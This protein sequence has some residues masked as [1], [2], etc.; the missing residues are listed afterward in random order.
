MPDHPPAFSDNAHAL[1]VG[2]VL[3]QLKSNAEEGLSQAEA[4]HRLLHYGP[5]RIESAPAKKWWQVLLSQ[6][7]SPV[8]WVLVAA[9]LV[10]LFFEDWVEA[11][12]IALVILINALIG[13]IMEWQALRSLQALQKL[14]K[15]S[16]RV[17]RAG[18]SLKI[19]AEELVPGDILQLEAGDI[20]AADARLLK[21]SNLALKESALTGESVPVSK[22]TAALPADTLLADRR[23]ML[24]SGTIITRGHGHALVVATGRES[25]LGQIGKMVQEARKDITP[26]EKKL[27]RLTQKLIILT[28]ILAVIIALIGIWRDGNILLVIETAIALAVAAIPEGLP[29]VATIALARGMLRL[30]QQQ[31]VVKN[32]AAVETLGEVNLIFTDKTGTLTEDAME[33]SLISLA[34]RDLRLADLKAL[35]RDKRLDAMLRV[36]SLC[37]N[38]SFR[39]DRSEQAAGDPLEVGLLK[40]VYA[41]GANAQALKDEFPRQAEIPFDSDHKFM[42]TLHRANEAYLLAVKGAPEEILKRCNDF[43]GLNGSQA[44]NGRERWLEKAREMATGGL[45]VLA[46]AHAHYLEKPADFSHDWTLLGLI[47]FLDPPR[48]DVQAAVKRCQLA[49]IKVVMV[50]GDHPETARN[51]AIQTGIS[52]NQNDQVIAG[53]QLKKDAPWQELSQTAVFARVSPAQKLELVN[54]YKKHQATV[55]M[56]GDGVNDAPALRSASIGIAMG[57]RGTEAAREAADLIL[58]D[59]AFPSIVTAVK[60][61]RIIFENIRHFVV[62]LLSCNISEILIVATASFLMLPMPLLP[63]QILFLNIVTDVFPAL[64]LGMGNGQPGI[65]QS[66]PRP[67]GEPI[68]PRRLWQAIL[69][70]GMA[71]TASII[72]LVVYAQSLRQL[73]AGDIN[74]LAFYTLILAQLWNVFNLPSRQVSLLRNEVT[75]NP[76]LWMALAFCIMLSV[77]AFALEPVRLALALDVMALSELWVILPFSLM[78]VLIIQLLKRALKWIE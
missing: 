19:D 77:A 8:V 25:Q 72:G 15:T 18:H 5:N 21:A 34:E 56:T 39:A 59:D 47:G 7:K 40:M 61:G 24:Y 52:H 58:K 30:S 11:I 14:S 50:T 1:T 36:A 67:A 2:A 46:I 17:I 48:E 71:I 12:A 3:L 13:L 78:P 6:F 16:A 45:R 60:Q 44:L 4:R 37:N 64:A 42:A 74:N 41:A 66:P 69:V 54:Q 29:I 62:Y 22:N 10:S 57:I 38:A 53:A 20:V 27:N 51:I 35:P 63:L 76:H 33:A 43:E 65:M 23:N 68:I 31:V 70:Y 9:T 75:R 55:A 73:S 32:L 26:L 28:L 49:G